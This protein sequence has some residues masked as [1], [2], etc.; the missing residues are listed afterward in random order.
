MNTTAMEQSI[1]STL[2]SLKQNR[3]ES[4]ST[5]LKWFIPVQQHDKPDQLYGMQCC[6]ITLLNH[7]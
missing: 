4:V 6:L 2:I 3:T 1:L 5:E 7:D